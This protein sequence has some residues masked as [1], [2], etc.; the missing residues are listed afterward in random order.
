M[1]VTASVNALPRIP[2]CVCVCAR[3]CTCVCLPEYVYAHAVDV[4]FCIA[5]VYFSEG[6]ELGHLG[7]FFC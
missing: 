1:T 6:G 3:A 2:V 5:C 7:T 4:W